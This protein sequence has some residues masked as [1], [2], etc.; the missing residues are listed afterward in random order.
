MRRIIANIKSTCYGLD[1]RLRCIYFSLYFLDQLFLIH[2]SICFAIIT[3]IKIL[4]IVYHNLECD[5]HNNF[6]KQNK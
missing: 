5:Y 6:V 4:F 1:D 2:R 3:K